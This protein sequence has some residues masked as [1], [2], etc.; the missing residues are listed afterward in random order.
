MR[1]LQLRFD[2]DLT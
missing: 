2:F 1:S